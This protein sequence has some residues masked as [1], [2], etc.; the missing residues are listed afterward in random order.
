VITPPARGSRITIL[1][2]LGLGDLLAGVPALRAVAEGLP[3]RRLVLV[4]PRALAPLVGLIPGRAGRQLQVAGADGL[5][6]LPRAAHGADLAINLHGRGPH[7]HQLMLASGARALLA[8]RHQAVPATAAGPTWNAAERESD[9]WC[10]LVRHIGIDAEPHRLE[11]RP[12]PGAARHPLAGATVI[13]PGA[14]SAA[15]RWPAQRFAAV[16]RAEAAA[17]RRVVVTGAPHEE[18]LARRVA[19]E[20]DLEPG[21]V[22]AGR[23]SVVELAA[24]VAVAGRVVCSDTGV[25]HLATAFGTPSVVVFGPVPPTVWG[26]PPAHRARHR[27]L[28]AG[29]AGD[30]FAGA[31]D[32]G[33]LEI[34]P[35]Q[36]LRELAALR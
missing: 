3:D 24:L 30:P 35:E 14:M 12:P 16:A 6:S 10:R 5:R 18:A 34:G 11:L 7:S 9:R 32:P 1:R 26:P 21:A 33:L 27:V 15:R 23:T 29:R 31:A 17:G 2:A 4:T 28:W 19:S 20:A 22:L 25:G 13:H 8:F 36:V